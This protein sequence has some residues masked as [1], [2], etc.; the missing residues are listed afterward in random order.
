MGHPP[1]VPV[2]LRIGGYDTSGLIVLIIA[3]AV[4]F[5]AGKVQEQNQRYEGLA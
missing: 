4:I 2:L 5:I 1:Q 3:V